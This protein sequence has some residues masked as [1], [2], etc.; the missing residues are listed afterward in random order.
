MNKQDKIKKVM[1]E[2]NDGKLKIPNGEVVTDKNQALAMLLTKFSSA[3]D[4]PFLMDNYVVK[5]LRTVLLE[6]KAINNLETIINY[7]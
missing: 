5:V 4:N 6:L 3:K 2:F 1:R 7:R